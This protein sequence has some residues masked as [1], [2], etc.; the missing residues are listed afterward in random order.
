MST[1]QGINI[2]PPWKKGKS[3]TKCHFL[4][5]MLVP[6]RVMT[7]ERSLLNP[8]SHGFFLA[9]Q[10]I[11]RINSRSALPCV[12]AQQGLTENGESS[13]SGGLLNPKKMK[14]LGK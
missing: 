8:S 2:S 4:G 1:L 11:G 7:P 5:D 10:C 9:L 6:S 3:S 14:G 13:N 12:T